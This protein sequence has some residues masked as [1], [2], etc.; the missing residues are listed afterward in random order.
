M[1]NKELN[2]ILQSHWCSLPEKWGY[3]LRSNSPLRILDLAHPGV[4][5][6]H[7]SYSLLNG[8]LLYVLITLPE[9]AD[10]SDYYTADSRFNREVYE[11]FNSKRI[12]FYRK[13]F[14]NA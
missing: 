8:E 1:T 5:G 10:I 3:A 13:E 6:I 11:E 12:V 14:A 7:V 2:L 9:D 4:Y